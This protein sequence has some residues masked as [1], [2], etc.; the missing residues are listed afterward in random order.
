M[1]LLV[2]EAIKEGRGVKGVL[3]RSMCWWRSSYLCKY[4]WYMCNTSDLR[5]VSISSSLGDFFAPFVV[6][7]RLR[8]SEK[9]K[10]YS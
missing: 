6:I 5:E 10:I 1:L 3:V 2:L 4:W 8:L 7:A 9:I